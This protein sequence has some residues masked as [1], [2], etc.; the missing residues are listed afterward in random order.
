MKIKRDSNRWNNRLFLLIILVA[1]FVGMMPSKTYATQIAEADSE[2]DSEDLPVGKNTELGRPRIIVDSYSVSEDGIVAGNPFEL[3][4]TIQNV[5]PNMAT[6][7]ILLKVDTTSSSIKNVY[8]QSNEAYVNYLRA[9][10]KATVVFK[11]EATKDIST[12]NVPLTLS[13]NFADES[14]YENNNDVQLQIPVKM[15]GVLMIQNYSLPSEIYVGTKARV[16]AT[17]ENAGIENLDD[18]TMTVTGEGLAEPVV[19]NLVSLSGGDKNY[20]ETY[21]EFNKAG[22]QKIQIDF[23]YKDASGTVH[24]IGEKEFSVQVKDNTQTQPN[25]TQQEESAPGNFWVS[26]LERVIV[27]AVIV[28]L[29]YLLIRKLRRAKR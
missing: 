18:I 21:V 14:A 24:N 23:S 17:Y 11:L 26:I 19:Q 20:T 1:L 9:Y 27:F 10:E 8:G 22:E 13:I 6:G 7:S 2:A 15:Q 5:N 3:T 12:E 29:S 28:L 25:P 16:S 4:V